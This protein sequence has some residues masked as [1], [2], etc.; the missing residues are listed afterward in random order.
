MVRA[1]GEV[2]EWHPHLDSLRFRIMPKALLV[3]PTTSILDCTGGVYF[4]LKIGTRFS[5]SPCGETIETAGSLVDCCSRFFPDDESMAMVD[6][7][8]QK[9]MFQVTPQ[10]R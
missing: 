5:R 1:G 4:M 7:T 6:H 2:K 9:I 8:S 3:S 10:K